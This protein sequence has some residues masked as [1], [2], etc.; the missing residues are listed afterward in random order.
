MW[1]SEI[2]S[3]FFQFLNPDHFA[4]SSSS[5]SAHLMS[6]VVSQSGEYSLQNYISWKDIHY[7][8]DG[9]PSPCTALTSHGND[10]VTVGEDGRINV[11]T[12]QSTNVVRSIGK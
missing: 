9:E 3:F 5:G 12:A 1:V 2:N 4:C 11:L 6:V 7:F 8:R 10:L